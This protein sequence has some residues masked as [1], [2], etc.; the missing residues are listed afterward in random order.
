MRT[1]DDFYVA[2]V[3]VVAQGSWLTD[4]RHGGAW[5]SLGGTAYV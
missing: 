3:P 5:G 4:F 2:V 1:L